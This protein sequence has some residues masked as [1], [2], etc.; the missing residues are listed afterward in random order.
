MRV[1]YPD[2]VF[3][4]IGSSGAP[5]L[6]LCPIT[7]DL[8]LDCTLWSPSRDSRRAH[9]LGIHGRYPARCGRKVLRQPRQL[10]C[11]H[12]WDAQ[13]Q[14]LAWPTEKTLWPRRAKV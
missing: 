4:A 10:D 2:L 11:H 5:C 7:Y 9:E 8:E 12:R 3:G 13:S 14:L 1:L 6:F